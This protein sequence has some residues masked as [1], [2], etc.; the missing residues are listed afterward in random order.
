M[1]QKPY[2]LYNYDFKDKAV[3][4]LGLGKPVQEVAQELQVSTSMLYV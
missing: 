4:L 1:S 3:A 2:L